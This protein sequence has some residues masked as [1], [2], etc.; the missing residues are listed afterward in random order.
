MSKGDDDDD[1]VGD[2][3][4][5]VALMRRGEP[6]TTTGPAHDDDNSH[7]DEDVTSEGGTV[8]SGARIERYMIPAAH[9][10]TV[11]VSPLPASEGI[12][13]PLGANAW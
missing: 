11:S 4:W 10:V 12:W 8:S 9:G 6:T 7:V 2:A 5:N 13:S 3:F 1:D